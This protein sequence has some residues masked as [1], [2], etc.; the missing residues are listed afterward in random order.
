MEEARDVILMC[1]DNPVMRINFST[2]KYEVVNENLLPFGIRGKLRKVPEFWEVKSKYEDTQRNLAIGKNRDAV[3]SWFANRTLLLSRANAKWIYNALNIDQLDTEMQKLKVSFI[4]RSVSVLDSYWVKLDGDSSSW[5]KIDVRR[6]HLNETIAQIALH[7]KS[8]M[9]QGSLATPELTTNGAYAKAWRRHED[10][11]WLYKL[12]HNGS[13]ESKIEVMVSKILDK[14][15][16]D[17]VPYVAGTDDG[18]YVCMCPC[19]STDKLSIL[20]AMEYSSYCNV[21]GLDFD[22]E[23]L[24]I[25]KDRFYKMWIVDY[26]ISNR[27]RHSQNWGFFYDRDTMEVVSTHPLFDHNNA[28][29]IE[30]MRDRNAVYQCS[31]KS[32]RE[33]AKYAMTQTDFKITDKI[34]REDFL[35]ERQYNEFVWRAGD[36][37][38]T[39]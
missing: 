25:D 9:I 3:V 35:T 1:G 18:K 8:V 10:G 30:Y 15:N 12:G 19:I 39:I 6:N 13:F 7:G 29:D 26:I 32:L 36:L 33:S 20:P 37:G 31:G 23:V 22:K 21:N 17:H 11:L 38:L 4:C 2:A 14:T 28:F 34:V 16:V 27:D 5:G 24:R